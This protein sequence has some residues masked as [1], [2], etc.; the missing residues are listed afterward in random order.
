MQQKTYP[1]QFNID[2]PDHK[3]NRLTT[4]FRI[5]SIIPIALILCLLVGSDVHWGT[6]AWRF[7]LASGAFL[8]FPLLL[9]IL[10]RQKYPRWWFNWNVELVKFGY[11]VATY[12]LLMND[13]YPSTDEEQWVHTELPY[14]DT[15]NGLN[16][17]MPIVKWF[18]AIPH[19]ICLW[20]VGIAVFIVEIIAWFA[21]LFTGNFPRSLFD[22]VQ[23]FLKWSLRVEAYA[24]LLLTNKYPPFSLE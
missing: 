8:F 3:L 7:G 23:G 17:W 5:F 4:F 18:L 16:R 24:F 6:A 2:Y 19:Y 1:I 22:F 20:A 21:I 11:R 9:M 14:P 12:F 15:K 10:F 13:K